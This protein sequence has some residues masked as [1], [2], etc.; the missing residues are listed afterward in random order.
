MTTATI[1]SKETTKGNSEFSNT[2]PSWLAGNARFIDMSGKLLGAHI[3]HAGLI[4]LWAGGMTL[5]E[6]AHWDPSLPMYNQSL[7]ILP[8]LATLGIGVAADG[9]ISDPYPFYVVG[10]LHL[11][12]SAVLGAGGIFHALLGPER[13]EEN[14][15]FAGFFGYDWEDDNKMTTI[16]GIHLIILGLG[17]WL[18]VAKALFVGGL[19]D[20][21]LGTTRLITDPTLNP[22]RIFGYLTPLISDKGMAGVNN[23][24]DVVGGHIYV[25][26]ICVLGGFWHIATR[27]FGWA[28]RVLIYSGEAYLSYSLGALAYMGILAAYFVTVNDT[29]YPEQFFGPLGLTTDPD[30]HVTARTWLATS[31]FVLAILFLGG[32]IWHALR[33]RAQAAGFD[34]RNGQLVTSSNS[35]VGNFDTPVNSSDL[36]LLFLRNLPIY[37]EGVSSL[38]RGL[39]IG[40]AHGYL[41]VG[42]FYKLGPLRNSEISLA[43]GTLSAIGLVIILTL[44]LS[45]YGRV[46][47]PKARLVAVAT[48]S[49]GTVVYPTSNVQMMSETS[50]GDQWIRIPAGADELPENLRTRGGWSQFTGG[51]LIGG[52]G[53]A[54]FAYLLLNSTDLISLVSQGL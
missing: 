7:I 24:E 25:G 50:D 12:A 35:Q 1:S 41:L 19:Y 6:I 40:M 51:F 17:A 42:P 36:T 34:F 21:H 39:E 33:A 48:T 45:I 11:I 47:F 16:I 9:V 46:S 15:T 26:L 14:D 8:H 44:C 4:M 54:L 13:L 49:Y 37:R 27:P 28:K 31:H 3:A 18:L 2:Q 30:G 22:G 20:S 32:H 43:V 10:V 5:F 23:L 38:M 29:V 53:G 52:V